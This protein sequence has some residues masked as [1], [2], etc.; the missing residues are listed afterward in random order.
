MTTDLTGDFGL[1]E[2]E[3]DWDV[4]LPDPD[5]SEIAAEAAALEDEAELDLDDSD[6]DWEAA[7]R[8]DGEPENGADNSARAGAAYERI[9]D[10]VRRSFEEETEETD[11]DGV[12]EVQPVALEEPETLLPA[13]PED[14]VEAERV[15][16][17][18][19]DD[20]AVPEDE[21]APEGEL[22]AHEEFV[23]YDEREPEDAPAWGSA[24]TAVAEPDPEPAAATASEGE[25]LWDLEPE[26]LIV[27]DPDLD[28]APDP[29]P[30][31]DLEPE[32]ELA[33]F[34]ALA[35]PT[36]AAPLVW[37]EEAA[38]DTPT[39]PEPTWATVPAASEVD[40]GDDEPFSDAVDAD[41]DE[42]VL[43][44]V[45]EEKKQRSRV[46]TATIVLACLFVV[47][48]AAVFGVRALR[49]QTTTA[50]APPVTAAP[51]ARTAPTLPTSQDVARI[52]TATDAVDSATTAA[53]VGVA[54]MTAFPTPT[55]VATIM[56]PYIASLQLYETVLSGSK[57]PAAARPAV[58]SA[59]TQLRQD[60]QF[61]DTID[62]LPAAQLGA[63]LAQFDSDA[64]HLQTTLSTLE[65][66]LRV[67]AS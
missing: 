50:T 66:N 46:F 12:A 9:V 34:S 60:L 45:G 64:T 53:S 56:N 42:R 14:E 16:A 7:L 4:F 63:Y 51:P 41:S 10:M 18:G 15:S 6:F 35:E 31:P 43:E 17:L 3:F 13:E 49:H 38:P 19:P 52:Q 57:V 2:D 44:P 65:Q 20:E 5:E 37:T 36:A 8:E 39:D 30:G 62:G 1:G 40:A 11:L 59:Q 27:A 58:A 55:S 61:L 23:T 54:S 29:G 47:V 25:P 32:P 48:V 26:M 67:P 24:F 28:L 33:P 21:L 22:T